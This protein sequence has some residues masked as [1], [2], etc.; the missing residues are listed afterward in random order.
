M[1]FKFLKS[2]MPFLGNVDAMSKIDTHTLTHTYFATW[3]HSNLSF[4]EDKNKNSAS[5]YE[6]C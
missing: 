2:V 4:Q 6:V 1:A 5:L 3:F